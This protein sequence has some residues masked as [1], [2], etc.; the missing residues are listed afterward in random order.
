MTRALIVFGIL[1]LLGSTVFPAQEAPGDPGPYFT[2][3]TRA[4]QKENYAEALVQFQMGL[5]LA[6]ENTA[7]LEGAGKAELLNGDAAAALGYLYDA[8]Q[9][10][11]RGFE[12]N[13]Y[14]GLALRAQGF[15]TASDLMTQNEGYMMVEDA[16]KF[17]DKAAGIDGQS[18]RPCLEKAY[19]LYELYDFE[20][21]GDAAMLA[22]ERKPGMVEALL[23]LGDVFYAQ[24]Q[25]APSEGKNAAQ[26]REIWQ[27]AFDCYTEASAGDGDLPG[28][29]L[30]MAALFEADRKWKES[31]DAYL[32]AIVRKPELT[33][34]YNQAIALFSR[35]EADGSLPDFLQRVLREVKKR[36]PRDRKRRATVLYYLGF[37]YFLDCEYEKSIKTYSDSSKIN[38]AYASA[39]SYYIFRSAFELGD[40]DRSMREFLKVMKNDPEGLAYFMENDGDFTKKVYPSLN[41]LAYKLVNEGRMKEAR[42]LNGQVLKVVVNDAALYNNYAFLCRETRL[43]EASYAA[44]VKALEIEPDNPV[45]LNDAALIL[46]YHLRRDLEE[47]ERLYVKAQKD[48]KRII[49]DPNRSRTDVAAAKVALRDAR[50]NLRRLKAGIVD[51]D[52]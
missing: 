47:A 2:R 51:D 50:N 35:D 52:E 10:S 20:A 1:I 29:W 9:R 24:Y 28:P 11:P 21:A 14:L 30:G 19:T 15:E 42:D 49:D 41:F 17:L 3:G 7:L 31:A 8:V 4:L 18:P 25:N 34:G 37:A 39:A 12:A 32:E 33:S 13:L 38:K 46:H 6:P 23:L 43:Y 5:E 22:L 36:Y 16:I 48:A 26:V 45:Y 27:A 40:H 44:Y